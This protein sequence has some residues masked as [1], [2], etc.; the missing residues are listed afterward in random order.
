MPW[1]K[2]HVTVWRE[3]CHGREDL[4]ILVGDGRRPATVSRTLLCNVQ[5]QHYWFS[6]PRLQ[7]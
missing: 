4:Q 5:V 2:K 1:T 7:C 3:A 6:A